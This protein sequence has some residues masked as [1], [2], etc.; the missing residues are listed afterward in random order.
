M[1]QLS[2]MDA[3]FLALETPSTPMHVLGTVLLD[4]TGAG[5]DFSFERLR[6]VLLGRIHLLRPFRRRLVEVPFGIDRPYWM[7]D[8]DF[9][10]GRHLHRITAPEPGD[11]AALAAVVGDI[12]SRVLPR[13]RPLWEI[14]VV[15]GL[16]DGRVAMV[17]KLH[18]STIYGVAGAS[19]IAHLFDLEPGGR[20]VDPP[21]EPFEAES[22]PGSANLLARA[23]A[24]QAAAPARVV[25]NIAGTLTRAVREAPRLVRR[26]T[27]GP[28]ALPFSAPRTVFNGA[29]TPA[30]AI[31]FAR[32]SLDVVKGIKETH[33]GTVN[34]VI[35]AAS[36]VSLRRYLEMNRA[37]PS[38]DLVA[39]VPVNLGEG[40]SETTNTIGVILVPLPMDIDDPVE[41]LQEV[42]RRTEA[43][44]EL[45]GA[46]GASFFADWADLTAPGVLEATARLY[47]ELRLGDR[48]RPMNNVVVSNIPGPPIPVYIAGAEVEAVIP[49]GPLLPGQGL[50]ITAM[51]TMGNLDVGVMLCPDL[52]PGVWQIADGFAAAVEEL[53]GA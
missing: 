23:V 17:A 28:G 7:N 41:V 29:L 49:F 12:A 32:T 40:S 27:S 31:A 1:E 38:R 46:L 26:A 50:N 4:P 44:K 34:D 2:G 10:I 13:D 36:A 25:G 22:P 39:S 11:R 5:G 48:H 42:T 45:S 53:A 6:E 19:M 51:S 37:V 35:L 18:H 30:R 14:W 15:D 20:D 21:E 8:G 9:D 47:D 33:G 24:H 52:S 16:A 43:D 3:A